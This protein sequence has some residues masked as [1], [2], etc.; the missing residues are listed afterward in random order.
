MHWQDQTAQSRAR[1]HAGANPRHHRG[2]GYS[3]GGHLVA[4]LALNDKYISAH[5]LKKELIPGVICVSGVYNILAPMS[6]EEHFKIPAFGDNPIIWDDASPIQFITN[7]C[8]P[9]NGKTCLWTIL[10]K[11]CSFWV[12][13]L[14]I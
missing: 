13:K 11:P 5:G 12:P 4:L 7:R 6:M 2:D 10:P 14:I 1:R 9:F 3:A 8:C